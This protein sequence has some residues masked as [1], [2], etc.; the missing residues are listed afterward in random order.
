VFAAPG[1]PAIGVG[2]ALA[3]LGVLAG[4]VYIAH[5]RDVVA[6]RLVIPRS[7]IH[8]GCTIAEGWSAEQ[9]STACGIPRGG[10]TQSKIGARAAGTGLLLCSAPCELYG[11]TLVLYGCDERVWET[12]PVSGKFRCQVT[13]AD[14]G[15]ERGDP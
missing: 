4:A 5:G 8:S 10:G 7:A 6:R 14:K 12:Q 13:M 11:E 15:W 9:V 3:V 1:R 2:L